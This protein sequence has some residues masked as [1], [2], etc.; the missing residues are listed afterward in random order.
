MTR[1]SND[2]D[3]TQHERDVLV[4]LEAMGWFVNEIAA[5]DNGP[6]FAYSFGLYKTFQHPEIIMFG[7]PENMMH[8]LINDIGKQ[9]RGGSSAYRDGSN[10]S[11]L[12]EGYPCKFHQV[13]PA[14]YKTT[15]TWLVGFIAGPTSPPFSFSG[16][17]SPGFFHGRRGAMKGYVTCNQISEKLLDES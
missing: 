11:D 10:S 16:Q 7:L 5:D 17:T 2:S 9:L 3:L 12:L 8:Q 14:W 13:D 6:G 15:L 4:R 1:S